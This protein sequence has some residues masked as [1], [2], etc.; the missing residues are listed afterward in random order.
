MTLRHTGILRSVIRVGSAC[1]VAACVAGCG[2]TQGP[3]GFAA[4]ELDTLVAQKGMIEAQASGQ[5]EQ[6]PD[7][8]RIVVKDTVTIQV[9]L[10]DKKTQFEGFPLA[11]PVTET[12]KLFIPSIGLTVVA[13]KTDAMLRT[14][15]TASFN[16]ILKS[17]TIVV[18]HSSPV[19]AHRAQDWAQQVSHVAIL[20]RIL[21]PGL[22]QFSHGM[23]V[24]DAIARAGGLRP[25]ANKRKIFIVRGAKGDPKV[26]AINMAKIHDGSDLSHNVTLAAN[27]AIYVPATRI[28]KTADFVKTLLLPISAIR[29]T[30]W[31]YDTISE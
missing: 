31:V 30:V 2:T 7:K 9:W 10:A 26:I 16:R 3:D 8:S 5:Q 4:A 12:G 14:E 29:D 23:T 6:A 18:E 21:K 25:Y 15:L 17:P 20:G 22:L 11:Q 1:L 19:S 28:W 27:D 24:R 13:E